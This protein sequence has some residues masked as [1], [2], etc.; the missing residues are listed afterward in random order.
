MIL[1]EIMGVQRTDV[2]TPP[3]TLR[4]AWSVHKASPKAWT[5]VRKDLHLPCDTLLQM[6]FARTGVVLS[7]ALVDH[8]GVGELVTRWN[9]S[10]PD[11]A[12]DRRV[13]LLVNAVSFRPRVPIADDGSVEGLEDIRQLESPDLF[14]QY[15]LSPK[16]LTAFLTMHWSAAYSAIFAFQIQPVLPS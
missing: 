8:E 16:A 2:D 7:E 1:F 14:E 9:A 13:V 15:L 6:H 5:I 3:A 10:H 4:W 11:T 12:N